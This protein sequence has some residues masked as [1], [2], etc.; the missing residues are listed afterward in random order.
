VLYLPPEI[1]LMTLSVILC[2]LAI[3]SAAHAVITISKDYSLSRGFLAVSA[4][5]AALLHPEVA[6]PTG[7]LGAFL[8]VQSGKIKFVFDKEAMEVFVVRDGQDA[9]RENFAVGGRN[10]WKYST[11]TE[12]AFLPSKQLPILMYF[13]ETQTKPEGQFH[14][15]PIII[16]SKELYDTLVEKVGIKNK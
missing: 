6:V 8:T 1:Y 9:S 14:L 5:S 11:F 12:W 3:L 16:N 13:K 4:L 15:F 7:L 2:L 10:R